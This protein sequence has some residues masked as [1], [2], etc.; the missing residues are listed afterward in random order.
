MM[1][2]IGIRALSPRRNMTFRH[3][4]MKA[5][6]L[7]S[8][9][10]ALHRKESILPSCKFPFIYRTRLLGYIAFHSGTK[11]QAYSQRQIMLVVQ[12]QH[13]VINEYI[14]GIQHT[15]TKSCL[16]SKNRRICLT[17]LWRNLKFDCICG[18]R[19]SSTRNLYIYKY[20]S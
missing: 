17:T 18:R 2:K 12:T 8:L 5:S 14:T 16:S 6:I 7:L 9:L 1:I 20:G 15:S 13:E 19:K 3:Y 11:W 4:I 10:L